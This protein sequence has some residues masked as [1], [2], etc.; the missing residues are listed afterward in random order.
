MPVQVV[1]SRAGQIFTPTAWLHRHVIILPMGAILTID[2]GGTRL[3]VASF[4]QG[5]NQPEQVKR[6]STQSSQGDVFSR[7]IRLIDSTLQAEPVKAIAVACPGPVNPELGIVYSMPNIP[8]WINFPIV[9]YLHEEY[10]VPVFVENDANLAALGEWTY[11]AGQ[12]YDDLIYVT[13]STGVGGG[14]ISGG[15]LLSGSRGLAAELGHVIVD[16]RGPICSCGQRG[17]LEAVASGPAIVRS[18]KESLSAGRKSLL[19]RETEITARDVATAARVGDE[20]AREVLTNAAV[21]LGQ[22]MAGFL[23]VFNPSILIFGGGVS[24]CGPLLFDPMKA[25]LRKL[26]MNEAYLMDL[27]ITTARLGDKAG[28]LGAL[29]L[30]NMKLQQSK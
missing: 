25:A 1:T 30:A 2:V 27:K 20:L 29:A 21:H 9:E 28:L 19:S 10:K 24:R 23:H 18:V 13:I 26:V 17:H 8:G 12:G 11:G 5:S 15:R 6:I 4:R 22:A 14:V 7:L 16:P 3:R